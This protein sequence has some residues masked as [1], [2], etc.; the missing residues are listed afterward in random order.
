VR[1]GLAKVH[2]LILVKVLLVFSR[3]TRRPTTPLHDG[4]DSHDGGKAANNTNDAESRTDSGFILEKARGGGTDGRSS[5]NGE[6]GTSGGWT[7]TG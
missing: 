3:F 2:A 6:S 5:T 4:K 1:D 7:V